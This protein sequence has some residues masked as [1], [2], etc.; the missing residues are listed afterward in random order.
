MTPIPARIECTLYEH[1]RTDRAVL[2]SLDG[3][4][5]RAKWCAFMYVTLPQATKLVKV[6]DVALQQGV[7]CVEQWKLEEFG[8]MQGQKDERQG[9]LL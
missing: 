1:H 4:E 5:S 9:E 7:F 8:W 6:R 2:L 3:F